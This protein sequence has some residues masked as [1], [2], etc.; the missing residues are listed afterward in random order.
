MQ[1]EFDPP[2]LLNINRRFPSPFSPNLRKLH[3]ILTLVSA[4]HGP[5]LFTSRD[6]AAWVQQSTNF[7]PSVKSIGRRLTQLHL[8][9][10]IRHNNRQV[11]SL[12]NLVAHKDQIEQTLATEGNQL[13]T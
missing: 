2:E 9:T 11:Y 12:A 10:D 6:A 7:K 5:A 8:A 1:T 4:Q 3:S 13:L